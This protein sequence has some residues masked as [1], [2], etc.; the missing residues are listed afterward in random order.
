MVYIMADMLEEAIDELFFA[1]TYYRKAKM[2][3]DEHPDISRKYYNIA[4]QEL[5]HA[6]TLDTLASNIYATLSEE[7]K[8]KIRE[9]FDEKQME[10]FK[11]YDKLSYCMTKITY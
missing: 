4:K 5:E 2:L 10:Y 1:K 7:W 9:M 6:Y 8:E 11:F 3:K